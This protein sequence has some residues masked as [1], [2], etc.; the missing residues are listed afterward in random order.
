M[1]RA[2]NINFNLSF[3]SPVL[4]VYVC[5]YA[6]VCVFSPWISEICSESRQKE[7]KRNKGVKRG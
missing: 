6:C 1:R 4:Y 2:Q 7:M 3:A 5:V